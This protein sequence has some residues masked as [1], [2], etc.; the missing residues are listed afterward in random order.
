MGGSPRWD[1]GKARRLAPKSAP[2]K[3]V[4][5]LDGQILKYKPSTFIADGPFKFVK[6]TVSEAKLVKNP[7]FYNAKKVKV[8]TLIWQEA[9]NA[10]VGE[11]E[12]LSGQVDWSGNGYTGAT[13]TQI[14]KAPNMHII[15]RPNY[16]DY[17]VYFNSRHYPLNM[18]KV[19]QAL[20]YILHTPK[21]LE[22]N[23]GVPNYDNF[24]KYPSLIYNPVAH[25]YLTTKQLDS[26]NPYKYDPAK[27]ASLLESAGFHKRAGHWY[28]P[29]GKRFTLT[30]GAPAGWSGVEL[31][32]KYVAGVLDNFGIST[33]GSAVEQPGYWTDMQD[34]QFELDWGWGGF[35][36]DPLQN[37][38]YVIGPNLNYSTS[39]AYKGEPGIGFG[40]EFD[41]PGIGRVNIVNA[42]E[43]ES[44]TVSY[45][46]R[47]KQLVWDWTKFV[48]QEVP[49]VLF[50]DKNVPIQFSTAR[51]DW[52]SPKSGLWKLMGLNEDGGLAVMFGEGLIHP[53]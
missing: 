38:E 27:A 29:N 13:W 10:T 36:T 7:D 26:L 51:Y 1:W 41:V 40:P 28:E 52:P 49:V 8:S 5:S 53:K 39:G 30:M 6:V 20:A 15:A 21:L 18:L 22:A 16:A 4:S 31:T 23:D 44:T 9:N 11:G 24:V 42:I 37:F 12:E 46:P 48:N 14:L 25:L 35:S 32:P 47:M 19:R 50:G 33:Q 3:V 34:G 45:G 2:G 43:R 17:A